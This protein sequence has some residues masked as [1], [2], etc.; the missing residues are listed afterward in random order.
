M[1][2]NSIIAEQIS[3]WFARG[4]EDF[5][6]GLVLLGKLMPN[7]FY[8]SNI[9]RRGALYGLNTL[10]YELGKFRD[11]YQK[12]V[13]VKYAAKPAIQKPVRSSVPGQP[14]HSPVRDEEVPVA[15]RRIVLRK[16][17]PFLS[18]DDCPNELKILVADMITSH[19]RYVKGHLRLFEV[20]HKGEKECFD[21]VKDTVENYIENRQIWAELEHYKQTGKILGEHPIFRKRERHRQLLELDL[22]SLKR[23]QLSIKQKIKYRKQLLDENPNDELTFERKEEMENLNEE[24]KMVTR[25]IKKRDA[26]KITSAK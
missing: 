19:D 11:K 7:L 23:E 2:D 17:F 1:E 14:K 16:E 20:A 10:R 18:Q 4:G 24:L 9:R 15:D 26:G 3:D 8:V 12:R 6:E 21:A 22:K 5:E 13:N 25:L